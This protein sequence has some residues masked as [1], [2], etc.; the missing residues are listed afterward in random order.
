MLKERAKLINFG[1]M[2]TDIA[3]TLLSFIAAYYIRTA[4]K[5]L[6]AVSPVAG[7]S[8]LGPLTDY[9]WVLVI[10]VPLWAVLLKSFGTY[11]SMRTKTYGAV[12][13]IVIKTVII[14]FVLTSVSIY[15][16]DKEYFARG[17]LIVFV[18]LN[19]TL[20]LAEKMVLRYLQ[21]YFRARGF[22][23]RRI[24]I[25]GTSKSARRFGK[26][27]DDH[28]GWGFRLVG[29][30]GGID[31]EPPP[32]GLRVLGNINELVRI[33]DENI[34]D[35]VFFAV[36]FEKI[37]GIQD[38][39]WTCEEVGVKVHITADFFNLLL[40]QTHV[41][42]FH[43]TP[44]LTSSPVPNKALPLMLKRIS[45]ILVSAITLTVLS[46]FLLIISTLIKLTSRGPVFY[47]QPR[48]GLYG[49]VF[50]VVKFRSMRVD[51]E[52]Y[53]NE[54][55]ALNEMDGPVFKIKNDPRTTLLG[56]LLRKT[57]IDELPQ[58]FNVFRGQMSLVGPRPL[59][60]YEVAQF[61]RWQRRRLSMK[62]GLTCLW[63]VGGRST[64][65]DF[66]DWMK[67]DL[68]YIDDWSLGLDLKI[69]LKTIPT[70]LFTRGAS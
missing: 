2:L 46:P 53:R 27:I 18:T 37:K 8:R 36:P 34:I 33:I 26:H 65:T 49:R 48:I 60:V 67:L 3:I 38:A 35:E 13:W 52:K 43:G 42:N 59:P 51:A 7:M 30:V 31:D 44:L 47:K 5:F 66:D 15:F 16:I 50:N 25:V 20:L 64:I 14:G 58:L 69:L 62:P 11:D 54:L 24:I 1:V 32:A 12:A 10:I 28:V 4:D 55:E 39:F 57:S 63:Q 29:F 17:I 6:E 9:Y 68:K 70:V 61:E 22:N 56:R 45:D 40:T 19:M 23:I 21:R 41:E